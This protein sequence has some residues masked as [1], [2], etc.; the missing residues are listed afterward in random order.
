MSRITSAVLLVFV[1][2]ACGEPR[3]RGETAS[4]AY[5]DPRSMTEMC[6]KWCANAEANGCPDLSGSDC[7]SSCAFLP[8]M[9][10]DNCLRLYKNHTGCLADVPNVCDGDLRDQ[11]C[12]DAY[13][14]MREAC[15]LPDAR[16]S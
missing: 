3:D 10:T 12:L 7:M 6:A 15:E 14:A 1:T 9:V 13:C 5:A 2:G 11:L 8:M 4:D 16:C